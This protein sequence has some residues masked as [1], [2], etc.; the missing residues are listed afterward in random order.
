MKLKQYLISFAFKE[1]D[2]LSFGNAV[3]TYKKI[4]TASDVISLERSI[5]ASN[6]RITEL[7]LITYKEI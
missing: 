1:N 3:G 2:Q 7:T 5:K 6:P 4:K